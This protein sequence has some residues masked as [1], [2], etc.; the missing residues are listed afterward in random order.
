LAFAT[1]VIF[2]S[3]AVTATRA[4]KTAADSF[5]AIDVA[6]VRH[7]S[8]DYHGQRPPWMADQVRTMGPEYPYEDRRNHREGAGVFRLALNLRTGAVSNVTILKST[9]FRSLDQ[10]AVIAL[11]QWRWKPGKWKQIEM[12]V[13]FTMTKGPS[14]PPPGADIL[15]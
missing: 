8:S 1:C 3:S 13:N 12:P 14:R 10:S 7:R 5:V 11:R 6:G 4:E 9:G 15:P 2:V